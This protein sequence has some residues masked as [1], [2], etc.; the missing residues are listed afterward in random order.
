MTQKSIFLDVDFI[1]ESNFD[2]IKNCK[3][4]S[5]ENLIGKSIKSTK[6]TNNKPNRYALDFCRLRFPR[7]F[8][9]FL[10]HFP[11]GNDG[12]TARVKNK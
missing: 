2:Q 7:I 8:H 3:T 12:Q 1:F 9:L 10:V 6:L 4:K 5:I 11:E